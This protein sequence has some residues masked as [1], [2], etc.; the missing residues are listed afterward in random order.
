RKTAGL[1][2]SNLGNIRD[3]SSCL[4]QKFD[5]SV[6]RI[7]KAGENSQVE[8]VWTEFSSGKR[9]HAKLQSPGMNQTLRKFF[10]NWLG[11]S[12]CPRI[13]AH[14]LTIGLDRGESLAAG[15]AI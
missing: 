7:G 9:E 15:I 1:N 10:F 8:I 4:S 14:A 6:E 2:P 11:H 13:S 5:G 12:C 3:R